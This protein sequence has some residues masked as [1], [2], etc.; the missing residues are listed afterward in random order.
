MKI[1]VVSDESEVSVLAIT[2]SSNGVIH[3]RVFEKLL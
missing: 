1:V 3:L 2:P